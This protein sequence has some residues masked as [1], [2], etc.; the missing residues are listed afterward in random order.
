VKATVK[1]YASSL[2]EAIHRANAAFAKFY[3]HPDWE[4]VAER[5]DAEVV[6]VMTGEV[7]SWCCTFEAKERR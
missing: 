7:V 5:A 2:D 1:I 3:G 4:V 6:H